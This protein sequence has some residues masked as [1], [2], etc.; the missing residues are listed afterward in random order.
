[1]PAFN[2][3]D[4]LRACLSALNH[5]SLPKCQFE[6]IV[7]DDG[8][9]PPLADVVSAFHDRLAVKYLRVPN[10]GP[11]IA[12]N[13]GARAAT[14]RYLA[15]T[16]HDCF[17]A[18]QW[19]T[20]LLEGFDRSPMCL[21]GG[22]KH[23]GLP[24]NLYSTAHQL[25]SNFGEQWFREAAGN[26]GYFTTNNMAVPREAFLQIGGFNE[27]LP[28]AHEDREF[29]ATWA[30]HEF[31][32]CWLPSAVV[33]H[34]HRLT[35]RTFLRQHFRYGAGAIEYRMARRQSP[36]RKKVPFAGLRFH[37]G[38]VL[39]PFAHG[40]GSRSLPLAAL[41]VCAQVAYFAGAVFRSSSTWKRFPS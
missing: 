19:L 31:P 3:P 27:A 32:V 8:S 14:G 40:G 6:V 16:D 24:G 7:V 1:V 25:A 18:P 10:R 20:A 15:F 2:Q 38:F 35:L 39:A 36:V 17:P 29:G 28:F 22:S 37:L 12:R 23:N 13:H 11:A 26:P 9:E 33:V 4:G 34:N 41:L 5:Q 30:D 21:L